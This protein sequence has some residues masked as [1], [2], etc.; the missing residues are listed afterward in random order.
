MTLPIHSKKLYKEYL[1]KV[2]EKNAT[3]L[4]KYH[5]AY[6]GSLI[7]FRNIPSRKKIPEDLDVA[8]DRNGKG[9][10]ELLKFY[11]SLKRKSYIKNLIFMTVSEG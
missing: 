5:Y 11:D 3:L 4:Q 2:F 8:V 7:L 6:A 9:V 10:Q 1:K